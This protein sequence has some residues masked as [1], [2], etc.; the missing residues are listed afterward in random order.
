MIAASVSAI[1]EDARPFRIV[2]KANYASDGR[3]AIGKISNF[4]WPFHLTFRVF[5]TI[6]A[7]PAVAM[8]CA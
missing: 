4:Q 3:F 1:I 6:R 8:R 5:R 7:G 2:M